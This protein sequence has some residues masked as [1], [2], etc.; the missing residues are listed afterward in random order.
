MT[1]AWPLET[2]QS[3]PTTL[4]AAAYRAR[5]GIRAPSDCP[6]P[7]ETFEDAEFP[8][9]LAQALAAQGYP[10][11]TPIQAQ[12]WPLALAVRDGRGAAAVGAVTLRVGGGGAFPAALAWAPA[13]LGP[14]TAAANIEH[15]RN[16]SESTRIALRVL[17]GATV[18]FGAAL[19]IA[20]VLGSARR[21][22]HRLAPIAFASAGLLNLIL[23]RE[24]AE[25]ERDEAI[26][27]RRASV[28]ERL[29][30]ARRPKLDKIVLHV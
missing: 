13:L 28:V 15:A 16:P 17:T 20:D 14:L 24:E 1:H 10:A 5:H 27:R 23:D 26:L 18:G 11:P 30:P 2:A 7:F 22:T 12:A 29:V 6:A 21:E 3:P 25:I 4:G 19:Y 9:A 8:P